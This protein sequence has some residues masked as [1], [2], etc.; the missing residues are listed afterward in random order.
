MNWYKNLKIAKKLIIGFLIITILTICVGTTGLINLLQIDEADTELYEK[1]T[2]GISYSGQASASFQRLRYNYLL[3]TMTEVKSEMEDRIVIIEELETEVDS[4]LNGYKNAVESVEAT[5]MINEIINDYAEFLTIAHSAVELVNKN[6]FEEANRI[7]KVDAEQLGVELYNDLDALVKLDMNLA[8]EKAIDNSGL[9]KVAVYTTAGIVIISII[10]SISLAIFISKVIGNPLKK[11]AGIAKSLAI[12]NTNVVIDITTKDEIGMLAQAFNEMIDNIKYQVHIVEKFASGDLTVEVKPKSDEDIL[13]IKLKEMVEQN[14][15]LLYNISMAAEHIASS[16]TQVSESSIILSQ[17]AAEQASS[18]QELT[19]SLE[20]I[21]SQTNMNAQ[22][23]NDANSKAEIAQVNA[24]LGTSK[25]KEM[26]QA[27]DDIN[28]SSSNISKVIKV[29]DDIAF[30]TNI[31]ALNAAVEAA[32]AGHLGKGF[33][34]VAEE[35]RNLAARSASAAKETTDMIANS[36]KKS[37]DGTKIAR[38]TAEALSKIVGSIDKANSLVTEIAAASNDQAMSIGQ[39]NLGIEQ[40]LGVVQSNSATSEENAAAS[41][42][43]ASQSE[44]LKET[45]AKYKLK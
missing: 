2:L 44:I 31:L 37:E 19:A 23:A 39:I 7:I 41:E 11:M 1:N 8:K 15:E 33:A 5:E 17:G 30:Q 43:L 38:E 26:L 14:K 27:M 29:I 25:M 22:K 6:E 20:E 40:V 12:G 9:A 35:V 10:V 16:A 32:R 24:D 3:L 45:V 18:V 36:I 42:E 4:S 34:V 28:E 21:S 13:G